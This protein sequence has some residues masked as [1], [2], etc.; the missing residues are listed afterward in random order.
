MVN[1]C[2]QVNWMAVVHLNTKGRLPRSPANYAR[3]EK[4]LTKM[5]FQ[6]DF[7]G[8][9]RVS[10]SVLLVG[11]FSG[12]FQRG[13]IRIVDATIQ[14]SIIQ[15]PVHA[16]LNGL[17]YFLFYKWSSNAISSS[18]DCSRRFII[19]VNFFM[20]IMICYI[21]IFYL[22]LH[23][24]VQNEGSFSLG[25]RRPSVLS[26]G[27]PVR[28]V[29]IGGTRLQQ[30]IR[31]F[32]CSYLGQHCQPLHRTKVRTFRNWIFEIYILENQ[33]L[34][35]KRSQNTTMNGARSIIKWWLSIGKR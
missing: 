28:F 21:F 34:F 20:N 31:N 6:L 17:V 27:S 2:F 4:S 33:L 25:S 24:S 18:S 5:I 12:D 29:Q 19:F 26:M 13:S 16:M 23:N 3:F 32:H 22:Q 15:S 9:L 7:Q 35:C 11:S 14:S 10:P 30:S 1:Y 8:S